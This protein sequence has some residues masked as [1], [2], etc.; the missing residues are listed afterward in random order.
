RVRSAFL[1][2]GFARTLQG[3]PPA[4]PVAR[5][6]THDQELRLLSLLD[7]APP[8]GHKRWTVRTLARAASALDGM[9]TISREL[10]RR[11]LKRHNSE[12]GSN[13]LPERQ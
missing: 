5:K 9:P 12:A 11:L 4:P 10:V 3:Q 2:D 7:T 13:E 6:L 1:H 8:P